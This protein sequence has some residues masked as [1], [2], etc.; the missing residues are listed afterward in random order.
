MKVVKTLKDKIYESLELKYRS[1]IADAEVILDLYYNN[2]SAVGEHPQ[3]VKEI[4][5]A[6]GKLGEARDKLKTLKE[7]YN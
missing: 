6:I 1:E 5:N 4:D 2:P 3:I 7:T